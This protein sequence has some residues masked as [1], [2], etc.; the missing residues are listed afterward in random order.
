MN[1]IGMQS[2]FKVKPVILLP[3]VGEKIEKSQYDSQKAGKTEE[4]FASI[5]MGLCMEKKEIKK[6]V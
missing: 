1:A 5:F 6:S 4:E 3:P 2:M